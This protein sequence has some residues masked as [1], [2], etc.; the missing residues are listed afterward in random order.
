MKITLIFKLLILT[1]VLTVPMLT[2]HA[3][4]VST[5]ELIIHYIVDFRINRTFR[6]CVGRVELAKPHRC[7]LRDFQPFSVAYKLCAFLLYVVPSRCIVNP[8][9]CCSVSSITPL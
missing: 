5:D 9:L 8:F 3:Q 7:Q 2:A 1:L 4:G 6:Q